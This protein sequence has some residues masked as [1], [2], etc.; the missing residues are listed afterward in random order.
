MWLG[1]H[2]EAASR[3]AEYADSPNSCNMIM[4]DWRRHLCANNVKKDILLIVDAT[5]EIRTS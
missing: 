3:G 2:Q 5:F 1:L 4:L